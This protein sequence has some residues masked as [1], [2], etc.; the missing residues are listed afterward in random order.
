M[1][2]NRSGSIFKM[3]D[4]VFTEK[5]TSVL[6]HVKTWC[7]IPVKIVLTGGDRDGVRKKEPLYWLIIMC[8][9]RSRRSQIT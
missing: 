3:P 7:I 5:Q 8:R 9:E 2:N 6:S 4:C 1:T